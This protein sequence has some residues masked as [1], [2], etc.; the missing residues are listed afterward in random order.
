LPR[1][2]FFVLFVGII[3]VV[4]GIIQLLLLRLLHREWWQRRWL[5]T[6]SWSL[7]IVGFVM[8]LLMVAGEYYKH[9]WLVYLAGPLAAVALILEISLMLSLP[10]SG[11]IHLT[12]RLIHRPRRGKTIDTLTPAGRQR[13]LIL[14]GAAAAVPAAAVGLGL[15]GVARAYSGALV[16]KKTLAFDNLPADLNGLR[17]LHL[18]DLHL[19]HY[20]TVDDLEATLLKAEPFAPDMVLVTG[21]VADD[22]KQLP[23]AL[24][25]VAQLNPPLGAF[26]SLGNHEYFR[27]IVEIRRLF[28]ESPIRLM[29]NEK[30]NVTRGNTPLCVAGIDDPMMLMDTK[31]QF[32]SDC[33]DRTF[34]PEP[35]EAF[36]V[37]MTHRPDAF[38]AA[39]ER[40]IRLSL[41]GHTHGGQVGWFG[42]SLLD[43][44]FPERFLW[45]EYQL[46]ASRL[47]TT[48]GMGHWFPFR[49]GCPAEAPIIELASR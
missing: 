28:D 20:V 1:V 44:A 33:L 2:F 45:G 48:C 49:L 23:D 9:S 5:R 38:P 15:G 17:I 42:R 13:R 46:G 32:F 6:A 29:V 43:G 34:G 35:P 30:V 22:L 8:F 25:L 31:S 4:P 40:G 12:D 14:Q 24:R 41:A 11:I 37:L 26:A 19:R 47:Y 16:E 39:S 27:G 18:S 21:D 7:P 10:L 3:I 36:T